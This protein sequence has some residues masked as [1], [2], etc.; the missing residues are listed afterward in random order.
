MRKDLLAA[1]AVRR[2]ELQD[3]HG[4]VADV[5]GHEPRFKGRQ[6]ITHIIYV[7][8]YMYTQERGRGREIYTLFVFICV[9]NY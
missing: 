4:V 2:E 5:K 3:D 1:V 8:I 7:Y 6:S 9:I